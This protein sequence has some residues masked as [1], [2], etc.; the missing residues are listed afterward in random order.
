MIE[1]R[2]RELQFCRSRCRRRFATK[3]LVAL[4][5]AVFLV[6]LAAA[7]QTQPDSVWTPLFNGTDLA[8]WNNNGEEKRVAEQGTILCESTANK[9]G[10]LTAEKNLSRFR[11]TSEVLR[12]GLRQQRRVFSFE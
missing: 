7:A 9:Y 11:S 8:G 3:T 10:Y 5:S 6:G 1:F 4:L 2:Q 12:R